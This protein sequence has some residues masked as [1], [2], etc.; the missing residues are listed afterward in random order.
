MEHAELLLAILSPLRLQWCWPYLLAV[1]SVVVFALAV[2]STRIPRPSVVF[3]AMLPHLAAFPLLLT[4]AMFG[5]GLAHD[6]IYMVLHGS[7]QGGIHGPTVPGSIWQ[8]ARSLPVALAAYCFLLLTCVWLSRR[9][10]SSE[11]SA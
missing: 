3:P 11:E 8:G 5:I 6:Y 7:G 4:L 1:Y 9:R 10:P 2:R